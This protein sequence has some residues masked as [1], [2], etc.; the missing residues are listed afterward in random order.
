LAAAYGC[1][2]SGIRPRL[3]GARAWLREQRDLSYRYLVENVGVSG[4]SQLR[5]YGLGAIVGVSAV[6]AIRG[7]EL[8]LGPFLAVLMGLSLVTVAEAA[9]VLRHAPHR[10]AK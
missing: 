9:R 8:L 4:A 7:A 10:L 6:G 5:A 2:Q 1:L 3:T